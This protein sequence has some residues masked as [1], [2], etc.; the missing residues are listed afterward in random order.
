M[1]TR[2]TFHGAAGTV[3]GSR[4]LLEIEGKRYL[5]DC[6]MFQGTREIRDKNWEPFPVDPQSL[7]GII[8]THAHT[9]HIGF[10]PKVVKDGYRGPIYA[11]PGTIGLMKVSL[12][13]GG[14]IQEEDARFH[15]KHKTS[16]HEP[17]LPLFTEA[18]AYETLKLVKPLHYFEWKELPGKINFRFM[19]AGHI[20]GSAF[21]EIYFP[22]GERILMGGDLGR[23]DRPII[24]DPTPVDFAEYL[25]IESTYGDRLHA[26]RDAEKEIGEI[27]EQAYRD[28]S[29][30]IIPSFAIGRTQEMLWYFNE[31]DKKGKFPDMPVYVD[32]PMASATTLLYTQEDDDHDKD[33]KIDMS[34]GKSPFRADMVRFVRDREMSK[35][36]NQSIGPFIVIA[37]SGMLTGGRVVFHLKAHAS[38]PN[39]IILFTGYQAEGTPGRQ[40]IDGA[41]YINLHG[42]RVP[43]RARV[44]Q[45]DMLSAHAD[46]EE[47]LRWLK[48]FKQEP[49]KTFIVHGEPPQQHAMAEHIRE[50]LGWT[51]LI[52]PT[53]SDSFNLD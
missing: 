35:Q 52:I 46:Y 42:D 2:I 29:I 49:K 36:L 12:P 23:Y 1:S 53:Q 28:R 38:D 9:D 22:N 20:L 27:L 5:V 33:M 44:H 17:A 13:D 15:N 7:D 10:L 25:V 31:L 40:I 41:E 11:T 21:A 50:T 18:D 19:P 48:G 47:M 3:T 6:G 37:G 14:R 51:N 4:H 16:R 30:V 24:K 8:I 26:H 32:S 43:V 34:E 39:T 45:L